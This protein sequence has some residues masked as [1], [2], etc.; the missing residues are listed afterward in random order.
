MGCRI[1]RLKTYALLSARKSEV[2]LMIAS[3]IARL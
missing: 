2:M 1:A 3:L